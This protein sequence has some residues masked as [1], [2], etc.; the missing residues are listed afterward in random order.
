MPRQVYVPLSYQP[1]IRVLFLINCS[2]TKA[3]GGCTKYDEGHT[4]TSMLAGTLAGRLVERWASVFQLVK[5][6]TNF[7]WQGT[8]RLEACVQSATHQRPGPWWPAYGQL[9]A[10]TLSLRGSVLPSIGRGRRVSVAVGRCHGSLSPMSAK[11]RSVKS[12]FA[13]AAVAGFLGRAAWM[14]LGHAEL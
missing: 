5:N 13:G 7:D 4:I 11:P 1:S 14:V 12:G 10:G 6:A 8:P 2:L 3:P 9:F